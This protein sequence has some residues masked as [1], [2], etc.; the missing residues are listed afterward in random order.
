MPN[1]TCSGCYEEVT[2]CTCPESGS[3]KDW[4]GR[5]WRHCEEGLS[6]TNA[7]MARFMMFCLRNDV[8][9]GDVH[10]FNANYRG[11][12][13][14]ASVRLREDQIAAFEAETKGKLRRPPRIVL[15]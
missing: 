4:K 3:E 6:L 15:N 5:V 2:A 12:Q 1:T 13:V 7:S 8:E 10:A 14:L 11:S 9:I